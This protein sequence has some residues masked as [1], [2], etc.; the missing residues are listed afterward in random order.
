[1]KQ[2][3]FLATTVAASMALFLFSCNN[4]GEKKAD[5]TTT[6]PAAT[7]TEAPKPMEPAVAAKPGNFAIIIAKVANYAKWLPGYEGHDTARIAS[8]LTNYVVGR[9]LGSDSN[10]VLVALK[11][12]DAAK[13]KAF[14]SSPGL[15]EA[16][17]SGGV[18]G[19]PLSVNFLET[20]MMDSTANASTR[21]I[22]THKVKDWDTW[23][24][25]FDSHKQTRMDAGLIDR[26]ISHSV[27]D[28]HMVTLVFA[29]TDMAKAKAF[30]ASK[31]LK[32]KMAAA[33][34]VGPPTAFYYTVA[35]KY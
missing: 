10:T 16:M 27:D 2:L 1:M 30:M 19:A 5:A 4:D 17:K 34:V 26:A 29:I 8:G 14:M 7:E 15:K 25:E 23:K 24:K 21:V 33:G 13:A 32:D 3:K 9:G 18:I 11:M 31:D 12:A 28:T 6:A 35:K 22:M 20:V